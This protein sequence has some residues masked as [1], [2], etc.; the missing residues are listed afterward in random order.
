MKKQQPAINYLAAASADETAA[1]P[2]SYLTA[3]LVDIPADPDWAAAFRLLRSADWASAAKV[4]TLMVDSKATQK[5]IEKLHAATVAC[6]AEIAKVEEALADLAEQR[7]QLRRD[8]VAQAEELQRIRSEFDAAL[9]ID[10]ANHI[11][12]TKEHE[13][14]LAAKRDQ[15]AALLDSAAGVNDAA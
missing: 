12:K 5:T 1:P 8:Q 13:R 11:A 9:A 6:H 15:F 3:M 14:A 10:R 4:C 7:D 2:A